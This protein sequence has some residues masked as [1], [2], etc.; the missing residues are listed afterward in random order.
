MWQL[1]G[2]GTEGKRTRC[3]TSFPILVLIAFGQ[4]AGSSCLGNQTEAIDRGIA[5]LVSQQNADGSW[6][7]GDK[8]IVDTIEVYRALAGLNADTNALNKALNFITSIPGTDSEK[9]ARKLTA[10]VSTTANTSNLVNNL[11]A[12]QNA[13]GGWGLGGKKQSDAY[14]A[15]LVVEAL[16]QSQIENS[17]AVSK[18]RD[19]LIGSQ[20]TD[21]SWIFSEEPTPSATARTALG[22]IALKDI[23]AFP[24]GSAALLTAELKAQSFLGSKST[25]GSFGAVSDTALAYLALLRVKQPSLLQSSLTALLGAQQNNGSWEG[26]VFTTALVLQALQAVQ[27]PLLSAVPDLSLDAAAIEFDPTNAESGDTVTIKVTVFN[28]G[29][30]NAQDV[31]VELF[32]QDPRLD[33]SLIGTNLIANIAPRASATSSIQFNTA[34]LIGPQLIVGFVDRSNSIRESDETNNSAS[35]MLLLGGRPD[36][37]LTVADLSAGTPTLANPT[38]VEL[39]ARLRNIGTAAGSNVVVRFLDDTNQ[40]G[41]LTFSNLE[42]RATAIATLDATLSSGS[43]TIT[44]VADPQDVI[45]ELV[46][47]NNTATLTFDVQAEDRPDLATAAGDISFSTNSPL[48]GQNVQVTATIHN[49]G[50]QA[51]GSFKVLLTYGDPFAGGAML[52]GELPVSSI[53]TNSSSQVSTNFTALRGSHKVFVFVDSDQTIAESNEG[54]N[55]ASKAIATAPLPDLFADSSTITVDHTDLAQGRTILIRALAVNLGEVSSAAAKA[56]FIDSVAGIGNIL[57]GDVAIPSIPAGKSAPLEVLWQPS[58]GTHQVILELDSD[59]V[60]TEQHEDNNVVERTVILTAPATTVNI[61]GS[62]GGTNFF[63]STVFGAHE[64]VFFQV[65][66][67]YSNATV[68]A[69]V[70]T[71][72]EQMIDLPPTQGNGSLLTFYTDKFPAGTCSVDIALV[73]NDTGNVLDTASSSFAIQTTVRFR[74]ITAAAHP[75]RAIELAQTA[76]HLEAEVANGANVPISGT[77]TFQLEDPNNQVVTNGTV[78]VNLEPNQIFQ[79]IT[80]AEF[81]KTFTTVGEYKLTTDLVLSNVVQYSSE[82]RITVLP[83]P[84]AG[85]NPSEFDLE[86]ASGDE[87]EKTLTI[88]LGEGEGAEHYDVVF[89]FDISGSFFD[90]LPSFR[91]QASSLIDAIQSELGDVYFGVA[92]FDDY[93]FFPWGSVGFDR[94]YGLDQ[95][96]T[97]D[98]SQVI[99]VLAS[100]HIRY[101]SD[102]PEAQLEG[103]YQVATGAGRDLPS[104]FD[105]GDVPPSSIGWR[106]GSKR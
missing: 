39:V 46:E 73:D 27:P 90:D 30:T 36:L 68:F 12:V 4:L 56:R 59:G 62:D 40:L 75:A 77:A 83:L 81:T 22:L 29:V 87:Q 14:D 20:Q 76:V 7:S 48:P 104:P 24:L 16:I 26:D 5:Y 8:Q 18:A 50:T 70:T 21:G 96:L 98:K 11:V 9:L 2:S 31:L 1:R 85:A 15:I 41:E 94:A 43:H 66:H 19:F 17:M 32:N 42:A 53:P 103:L 64:K 55:L 33:G 60:V 84:T 71:P 95:P 49:T 63:A 23:E 74:G 89:L 102:G 97:S 93:P 78:A 10:L 79:K 35:K 61:L 72:D 106:P 100:I 88:T 105:S 57:V 3:L 65:I 80:F 82:D 45:G 51:S 67:G 47:T 58:F 54:N 37:E 69:E 34:G 52:I 6:S 25:N 44:V 99:S 91:S 101:G 92:T 28:G 86:L 13:D 38:Q